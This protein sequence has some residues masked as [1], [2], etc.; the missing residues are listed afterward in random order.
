M[1]LKAL[2][3][4]KFYTQNKSC[5]P[6]RLVLHYGAGA[7]PGARRAMGEESL[8]GKEV[9]FAFRMEDHGFDAWGQRCIVE[10]EQRL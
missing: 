8:T 1:N 6:F 4:A 10:R 9:N 2:A 7:L 5:T 3:R